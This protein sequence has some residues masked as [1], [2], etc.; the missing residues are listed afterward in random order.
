[1]PRFIYGRVVYG[2][3]TECFTAKDT[4]PGA[5][6]IDSQMN[7]ILFIDRCPVILFR[8]WKMSV[9][10]IQMMYNCGDSTTIWTTYWT[11][12]EVP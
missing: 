2:F 5:Y 8:F 4:K 6:G 11:S 9:L 1:M 10:N 12:Y 3:E 7:R